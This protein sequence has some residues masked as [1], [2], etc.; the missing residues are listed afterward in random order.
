MEI[1]LELRWRTLVDG[2]A[3]EI[4]ELLF[5]LLRGIAKG[6]QLNFAAKAEGVSYRHAWGLIR[7]WEARLG[8]PLIVSVQGRG[9]SLT[10]FA[11]GLLKARAETDQALRP[12]LADNAL[13]AAAVIDAAIKK[14][15]RRVRIASSHN[16]RVLR[17]REKL[18]A[19][20]RDVTLEIVGSESALRQYRRGDADVAGFH[21]PLGTLGRTVGAKLIASLV[22][23]H[24]Q[25]FL[26]EQRILGLMSRNEKPC[27]AVEEL[28]SSDLQFV[29]RQA[30][31]ATRLIFDGLL[32]AG[33]FPSGEIKGYRDEEYTHTAVGALV[34]SCDADVAF[35]SQSAAE[36]FD[37][38]F[39]AMVE[40]R[41]YVVI[42]REFDSDI[43]QFVSEFCARLEFVDAD[44]MN[45]DE[46]VPTVAVMKRVHSAGS[47]Q[48]LPVT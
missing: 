5:A 35:G 7:A 45:S 41:F 12:S 14:D 6:G 1:G 32:G 8:A 3:V 28:I 24:D 37:L 31:S 47:W 29:N 25:I 21:L 22:D 40:E 2:E 11:S 13:H 19:E 30:G 10:G 17:L 33:A 26:I 20:R 48:R 34:V 44:R 36:H 18:A 9:A 15:R 4:D 23:K 16:D 46:F 38:H 43:K 42:N 27:S 39:K